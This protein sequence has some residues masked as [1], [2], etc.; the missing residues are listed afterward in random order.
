MCTSD[1]AHLTLS[2]NQ[3]AVKSGVTSAP[4]SWIAVT[5]SVKVSE[6][7]P[8]RSNLRKTSRLYSVRL[9]GFATVSLRALRIGMR[10]KLPSRF[11]RQPR[12]F[13]SCKLGLDIV[14][15]TLPFLDSSGRVALRGRRGAP[16]ARC[17]SGS[18]R[19]CRTP[20]ASGARSWPRAARSP[21][22]SARAPRSAGMDRRVAATGAAG[23]PA[24]V[25]V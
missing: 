14:D 1:S 23:P 25:G 11:R 13:P 3:A 21:A 9:G 15:R 7:S 5:K 8:R 24:G 10:T 22:R 2:V 6:P 17:S 12:S 4:D 16:R 20:C 19:G 18:G